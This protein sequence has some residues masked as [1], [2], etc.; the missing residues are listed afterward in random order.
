[1]VL[2]AEAAQPLGEN[3]LICYVASLAPCQ[4]FFSLPVKQGCQQSYILLKFNTL[5]KVL[6]RVIVKLPHLTYKMSHNAI[7][8]SEALK[9]NPEAHTMYVQ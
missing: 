9:T 4:S 7:V 5:G 2:E 1:M 8:L 6:P 3:S